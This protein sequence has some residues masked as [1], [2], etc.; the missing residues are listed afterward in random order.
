MKQVLA[1]LDSN[2][3]LEK[4][5]TH[6]DR[7]K[8]CYPIGASCSNIQQPLP[9][10]SK[11]HQ[12]IDFDSE[13]PA[14]SEHDTS[15]SEKAPCC[16]T[17]RR[18]PTS[19]G[20][21]RTPTYAYRTDYDDLRDTVRLLCTQQHSLQLNLDKCVFGVNSLD[22]LGHH[23]GQ[24]GITQL[25]EKV[26]CIL[27]FP[28]PNT[29]TQ[30]RRFIGLIN[31]YRRFIPHCAAILAPLTD[32][33]KSKAKPIELSPAAHTAFEEAKKAL[34]DAA[35]PHHLSSDAHAQLILTTDASSSTVGA[36]LHQQV[37]NQLQPLAFFSQKLQP[38]QTRYSTFSRELLAIYLA[39]RHTF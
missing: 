26:Q 39:I 22:F 12:G 32:L 2:T 36:V 27:P 7:I 30:L 29:L 28:V 3:S 25:T 14:L 38:A 6:T 11:P 37:K 1:M 20:P 4:L 15:Y 5:A 31:Y 8:E 13:G 18:A 16:C 23:V 33:L 19:A 17:A 21:P 35:M 34:A 9:S 10:K 24:H